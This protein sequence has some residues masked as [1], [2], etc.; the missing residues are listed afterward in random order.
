MKSGK[1]G[2][3][4][5]NRHI[6]NKISEAEYEQIKESNQN[7]TSKGLADNEKDVICIQSGKNEGRVSSRAKLPWKL[8]NYSGVLQ[9]FTQA[10]IKQLFRCLRGKTGIKKIYPHLLKHTYCT[11]YLAEG[12]DIFSLR[13]STEHESFSVLNNYVDLASTIVHIKDKSLSLLDRIKV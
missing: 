3:L 13:L 7:K 6:V 4:D 5:F 1:N 12:G 2:H 10:T 11:M 8:E 9:R